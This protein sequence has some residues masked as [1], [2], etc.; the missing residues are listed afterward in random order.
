MLSI[1]DIIEWLRRKLAMVGQKINFPI[2]SSPNSL[3]LRKQIFRV[4]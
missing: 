3:V 2:C 4:V 1:I